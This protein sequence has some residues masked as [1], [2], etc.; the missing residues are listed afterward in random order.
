M[1]EA[2]GQY[3]F[4]EVTAA[5]GVFQRRLYRG[6]SRFGF[7]GFLAVGLFAMWG[8]AA[9]G[10]M[11]TDGDAISRGGVTMVAMLVVA[12][13]AAVAYFVWRRRTIEALW[14]DRGVA[15]PW[16][17]SYVADESGFTI[18]QPGQVTKIAWDAVTEVAPAPT[19]WIFFA[20]LLGHPMPRKFFADAAAERAFIAEVV[21]HLSAE[22]RAR[23]PEAIAFAQGDD[24]IWTRRWTRLR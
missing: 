20:N 3:R 1:P 15:S 6:R 9:F 14:R 17:M 19:H 21:S 2:S 18:R 24:S 10:S 22:A 16:A 13:P 8:A 11:Q 12:A 23:S 7:A 4:G 5:A